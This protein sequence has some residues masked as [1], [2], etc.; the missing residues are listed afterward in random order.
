MI[1]GGDASKMAKPVLGYWDVRGLAEPIRLMLEHCAIAY[2]DKRYQ[3]GKDAA[4]A[5]KGDWINDKF[6]LGLNFPNIPY[7]IDG[8]LK[9]S[10]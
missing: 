1:F 10:I 7:F 8:D 3:F 5:F 4:D 2:K 9:L 6:S